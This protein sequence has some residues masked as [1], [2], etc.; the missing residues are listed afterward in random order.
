[1][2]RGKAEAP[3]V[4]L[5][6]TNT[7]TTGATTNTPTTENETQMEQYNPALMNGSA[8][9]DLKKDIKPSLLKT[10][11]QGGAS[12]TYYEWHTAVKYLDHFAPGW[13]FEIRNVVVAEGHIG[14]VGRLSIPCIEGVVYRE[15]IGGDYE[16]QDETKRSRGFDP[17]LD[18]KQQAFKRCCA[19]FG[20][21]LYLYSS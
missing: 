9:T 21:G 13:C 20:F 3:V 12:L 2:P 8:I 14:V 6:D 15:D 18:A 17:L 4:T 7:A 11:S 10:R 19:Q 16:H 5:E 1:M